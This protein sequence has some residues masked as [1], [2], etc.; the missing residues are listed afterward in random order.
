MI[1]TDIPVS[2]DKATI[3]LCL[4]AFQFVYASAMC[5]VYPGKTASHIVR[6]P[7][8]PLPEAALIWF[9]LPVVCITL[10]VLALLRSGVYANSDQEEYRKLRRTASDEEKIRISCGIIRRGFVADRLLIWYWIGVAC[11]FSASAIIWM[12]WFLGSL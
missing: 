2:V 5:L 7:A 12:N 8:R 6:Y 3:A 1:D 11:M 4:I 9:T 10:I